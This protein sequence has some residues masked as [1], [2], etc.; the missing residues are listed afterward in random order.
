MEK[1]KQGKKS[2]NF[3]QA[4]HRSWT[5]LSPRDLYLIIV[6]WSPS[7]SILT[8]WAVLGVSKCLSVKNNYKYVYDMENDH[9]TD[10]CESV[11]WI[12]STLANCDKNVINNTWK[13][14]LAHRVTWKAMVK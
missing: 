11:C 4:G 1:R 5:L 7:L 2:E 8:Y 12:S 3:M 13:G 10:E 9:D 14:T 6:A